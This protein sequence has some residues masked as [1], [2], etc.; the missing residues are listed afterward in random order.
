M[1]AIIILIVSLGI[2]VQLSVYLAGRDHL[3]GLVRFL[4][5]D[6]EANLPAWFSSS[7]LLFCA[8]VMAVIA[9]AKSR[10]GDPFRR[11][12]WFLTVVCVYMSMDEAALVHDELLR[13]VLAGLGLLTTPYFMIWSSLGL[14]LVVLLVLAYRDFMR[15]LPR[16]TRTRFYLAAC[17]YIGGALGM[18]MVS[19]G[20]GSIYGMHTLRYQ[21]AVAAE[22]GLEMT[23]IALFLR[24]LMIYAESLVPLQQPAYGRAVLKPEEQQDLFPLSGTGR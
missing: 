21:M 15:E 5:L 12:W 4:D 23:G 24:A 7:L 20:L 17:F 11:H 10:A 14:I 1:V 18:E 19:A 22:E 16:D 3:L 13:D 9:Q 2:A 6:G 8:V